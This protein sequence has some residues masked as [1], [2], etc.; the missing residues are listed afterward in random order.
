MTLHRDRAVSLFTQGHNCAQATVGAFAED[1]GIELQQL[2]RMA[3]GFGAGVGGLRGTCG[4][5][6]GMVL[7][8]GLVDGDNAPQD[9]VSKKALYD[10]IKRMH[11]Q[12]VE[13]HGTTC[14]RELL[15]QAAIEP[16]G[17]PSE[18]T[19]RYYEIRPCVRFVMTA[20]EIVE[21]EMLTGPR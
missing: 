7:V 13:R 8:A 11:Q 5:V 2:L 3:S 20:T 10:R 21:R 16:V 9:T 12:F 1:L 19:A 4:A 14:C 6:S 17:D 15:K 18:R